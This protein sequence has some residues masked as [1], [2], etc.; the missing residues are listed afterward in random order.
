MRPSLSMLSAAA[1]PPLPN[2]AERRLMVCYVT[3]RRGLAPAASAGDLL[4]SIQRAIGAGVDWIQIREKDLSGRELFDLAQQAVQAASG[5]A[6]KILVNDRL[7]VA[8][9]ADASGVHL[10]GE[11]FPVSA[12]A[13]WRRSG[14]A[15]SG[16][17]VGASCHTLEGAVAAERDGA[18]YLFF[19]PIFPTPSKLAFGPPQGMEHLAEV[20][21]RIRIPVLAIGGINEENARDC[22]RAGAA[23][24]AA[25]RLFQESSNLADVV[26]RLRALR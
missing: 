24:I 4:H 7:D 25:I 18:D 3:D 26:A 11:S 17:L 15:P 16:F 9:A 10:G 14:R 5:A 8:L 12:A 23:G 6:V 1:R 21:R 20:C 2:E 13:C 19:G 22:A